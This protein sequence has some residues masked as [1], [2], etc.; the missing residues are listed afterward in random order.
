MSSGKQL[1]FR[2]YSPWSLNTK[3]I[4]NIV[5]CLSIT[6]CHVPDNFNL[7][8][9][10]SISAYDEIYMQYSLEYVL[11]VNVVQ[12]LKTYRNTDVKD[13]S[14]QK[15]SDLL[16]GPPCLLLNGYHVTFPGIKW[17]GCE[18]DSLPPSSAKV[19]NKWN[20]TFSPP[21]CPDSGQGL[22]TLLHLME[23]VV[24]WAQVV[25]HWLL[26]AQP[27]SQVTLCKI[28]ESRFFSKI[29]SFAP[30]YYS[31]CNLILSLLAMLAK[32]LFWLHLQIH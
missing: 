23:R 7:Q 31:W 28:W 26:T 29:F 25:S 14:L 30:C 4:Q 17:P 27:H 1:I 2:V 24:P 10:L 20:Y 22:H 18:V 9:V 16:W 5:K 19:K 8:Y 12:H 32:I 3:L 13:F 15:C 21:V 11:T 6:W